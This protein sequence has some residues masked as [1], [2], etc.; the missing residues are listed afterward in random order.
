MGAENDRIPKASNTKVEEFFIVWLLH[1]T[2]LTAR[3]GAENGRI[4]KATN[5]KWKSFLK[6]GY[7]TARYFLPEREL[8][9][10]G[11]EMP[12]SKQ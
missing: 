11:Y 7:C 9:M 1:R 6:S 5:T 4:R 8:K 3:K 10:A 12:K 2:V